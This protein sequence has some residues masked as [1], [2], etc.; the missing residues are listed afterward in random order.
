MPQL[1][2]Q[3]LP[4]LR[5]KWVKLTGAREVVQ[6]AALHM[7]SLETDYQTTLSVCLRLLN[8]DPNQNWKVNLETGE[9]SE[10]TQ[11]DVIRQ[12]QAQ[13]RTNGSPELILSTPQP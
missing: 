8:L 5:A 7:Q 10:V 3:V 9:I 2:E 4:D 1:P 11:A 12:Q 13:G 6:H